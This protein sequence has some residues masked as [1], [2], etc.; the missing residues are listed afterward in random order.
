MKYGQWCYAAV[1][2][3]LTKPFPRIL[4]L[5][6]EVPD[7][8]LLNGEDEA[9]GFGA[10]FGLESPLTEHQYHQETTPNF[11]RLFSAGNRRNIQHSDG[12]LPPLRPPRQP[13]SKYNRADYQRGEQNYDPNMPNPTTV[14]RESPRVGKGVNKRF[15]EDDGMQRKIPKK[16]KPSP[17][18]ED[19]ASPNANDPPA[20]TTNGKGSSTDQRLAALK[21]KADVWEKEDLQKTKKVL[22]QELVQS[23]KNAYTHEYN[24]KFWE[25][26]QKKTI[27]NFKAYKAKV[28]PQLEELKELRALI[29]GNPDQVEQVWTLQNDLEFWKMQNDKTKAALVLAQN[30]NDHLA[31]TTTLQILPKRP[32]VRPR[33]PEFELSYLA[34]PVRRSPLL[35]WPPS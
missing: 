22:V 30:K 24:A 32:R 18:E 7:L 12:E 33:R 31:R 5:A 9:I 14:V 13:P 28:E 21:A 8:A 15:T 4:L 3:L 16:T 34:N 6:V 26:G 25:Q 11:Q 29:D 35:S 2:C 19:K 10:S 20:T 23:K 1:L 27:A 17:P